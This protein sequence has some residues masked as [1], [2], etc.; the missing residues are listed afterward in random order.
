[1]RAGEPPTYI[2]ATSLAGHAIPEDRRR[3]WRKLA[4]ITSHQRY[5]SYEPGVSIR[6]VSIPL[7]IIYGDGDTVTPTDL[8]ERA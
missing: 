7:L 4:T 3:T 1:M 8:I 6:D 5:A 2:E